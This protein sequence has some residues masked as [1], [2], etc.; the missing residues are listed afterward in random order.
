[1]EINMQ[2]LRR[3][4]G[5]HQRS[6]DVAHYRITCASLDVWVTVGGLISALC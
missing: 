3:R 5:C 2:C 4:S 6:I 1:M